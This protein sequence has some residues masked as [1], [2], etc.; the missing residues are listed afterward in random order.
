MGAQ[1]NTG[2]EKQEKNGQGVGV[3]KDGNWEK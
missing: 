1:E 2:Y 3:L